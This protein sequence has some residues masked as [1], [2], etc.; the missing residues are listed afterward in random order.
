MSLFLDLMFSDIPNAFGRCFSTMS[1]K[2]AK[3]LIKGKAPLTG[4]PK[5]GEKPGPGIATVGST[6]SISV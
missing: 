1:G 4:V 6:C 5:P 2:C 3:L